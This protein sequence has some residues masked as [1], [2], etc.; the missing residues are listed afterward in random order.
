MRSGT[1]CAHVAV[2]VL[3]G[4]ASTRFAQKLARPF[5]GATLLEHTIRNVLAIGRV[6]V[7][8]R[9]R[10]QASSIEESGLTIVP[11]ERAGRGP[12]GGL[13]SAFRAISSPRR[14]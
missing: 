3:A 9:D 12:L 1:D 2:C 13:V 14:V 5:G 11:D 10:A 4:G 8:V 7:S 6:Y